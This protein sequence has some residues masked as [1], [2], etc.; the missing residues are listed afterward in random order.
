MSDRPTAFVEIM[1]SIGLSCKAE[2][3]AENTIAGDSG[4]SLAI[5][6][7]L[8]GLRGLRGLRGLPGV[9]SRDRAGRGG[10][11]PS[12]QIAVPN[13]VYKQISSLA[14]RIAFLLFNLFF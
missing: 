14:P 4:P 13:F 10:E 6:R 11:R 12:G 9:G 3:A 7:G 5:Q 2:I 8:Q 1:F